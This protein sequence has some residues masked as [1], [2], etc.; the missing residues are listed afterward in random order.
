MNREHRITAD[1][2]SLAD[3]IVAVV[4]DGVIMESELQQRVDDIAAKTKTSKRMIYYYFGDKE[5]LYKEA[6]EREYARFRKAESDLTLEHLEPVAALRKLT[7]FTFDWHR[8]N[9][10]FIR[11]VVIENAVKGRHLEQ[12]ET[13]SAASPLACHHK[14]P[15]PWFKM[16]RYPTSGTRSAHW[17]RCDGP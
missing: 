1:L 3:R 13:S 15:S 7:E 6:L 12:S 14:P 11:L 16:P 8:E 4:N 5:G 17:Q 10:D 2:Q 9:P